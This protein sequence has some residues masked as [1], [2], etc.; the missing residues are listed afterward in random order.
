MAGRVVGIYTYGRTTDVTLGF[1]IPIR[2]GMEL[3]GTNPVLSR[4]N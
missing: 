4:T 1:C 3:M 2:F